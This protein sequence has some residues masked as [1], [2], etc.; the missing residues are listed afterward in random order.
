MALFDIMIEGIS[1]DEL[2]KKGKI[3]PYNYYAPDLNIDFSGIKK[4]AGDY[5]TQQL[6]EKMSTKKIYGDILKYYNMLANGKNAIAY[7]TNVLHSE[8]VRD[9]FNQNGIPA[10]HIDASTPEKEREKVLEDFEQGKFKV[11]CNCNLISEGITLPTA[12][13]CLMLRKTAS[14]PLFIQQGCRA[15]T[16]VEGKTA[17]IIDFTRKC[18]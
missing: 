5:N 4:T 14:L 18:F 7:C 15:L 12:E 8:E 11:L 10:V 6:S 16:P 3:S 2:I 9:M 1:A 13:A 17:V